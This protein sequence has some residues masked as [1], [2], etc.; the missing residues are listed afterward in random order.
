MRHAIRLF[1]FVWVLLL[2][3]GLAPGQAIPDPGG[4]SWAAT[5]AIA[6]PTGRYYR[7][8]VWTGTKMI[9]WGGFAGANLNTGGRYSILSLYVKN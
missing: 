2:L 3:A 6:A 9:V 4:N 5:T 1:S 8:A 7:T